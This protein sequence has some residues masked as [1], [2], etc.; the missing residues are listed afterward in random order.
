MMAKRGQGPPFI[1]YGRS[2]RNRRRDVV[3]WL[4]ARTVIPGSVAAS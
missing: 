1:R 2:I 4:D 3:E